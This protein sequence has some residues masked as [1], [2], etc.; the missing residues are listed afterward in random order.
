M[1][2]ISCNLEMFGIYELKINNEN[3]TRCETYYSIS[4]SDNSEL[5]KLKT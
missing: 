3:K 1:E 5:S 2:Y 4:N